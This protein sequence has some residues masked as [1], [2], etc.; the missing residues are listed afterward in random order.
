MYS[1][2]PG[3][4]WRWTRRVAQVV[5]LV[6]IVVA[7]LLGG[8]QRM[9]HTEM[10]KWDNNGWDLPNRVRDRL[11][12]GER[13]KQAYKAL[14]M[15]GGGTAVDY[16]SIPAV[17]PVVGLAAA[18]RGGL[19]GRFIVALLIPLLIGLIAG[20]LFCGWLCPFG[21]LSRAS[22]GIL[23]RLPFRPHRYTIP[24][25]R[26]LRWI[27]LATTV[28]VSAVGVQLMLIYVLPHLLTQQAIYSVW[29]LGGGGAA[30]G[31]LLGLLI[32]GV[33]FGPTLYC[34]T[35]CPTGAV[36]AACGNA[37]A[38]RVSLVDKAECGSHC[39][40]CDR[41]CWLG[42]KP[43]LGDPGPDC[44]LCARCFDACPKANMRVSATKPGRRH[45]PVVAAGLLAMVAFSGRGHAEAARAPVKPILVLNGERVYD[46][47]T[48]ATTV[49]DV[50]GVKLDPDSQQSL[51]GVELS[52]FIAR[53]ERPPAEANGLLKSREVYRG[54]L[55]ITITSANG[56][57]LAVLDFAKPTSPRSTPR[58]TLYRKRLGIRL[59]EGD[60][61]AFGPVPGWID[62]RVSWTI[63]GQ[64]A[65][66]GPLGM[67]LL[68]FAA[69]LGYAGV[70][71]LS[72]ALGRPE[73]SG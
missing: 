18:T 58:G 6:V 61:V 1:V 37:R 66:R 70:L 49:V 55:R 26:T 33:V 44:D 39:T 21:A 8:W 72:L 59:F 57:Q 68:V 40:L 47:V 65:G 30:L 71:S 12:L 56:K 60:T 51:Q 45:L 29:L 24:E 17:D 48:V 38:L 22:Q 32:A 27:I 69:A 23:K 35:L 73:P 43:S 67:L 10:A 7:P 64:G 41:A 19:S 13:P 34:A 63:P 42:L 4:G 36:L 16:A 3:T 5:A 20:R 31:A 28:L 2:S 53:G 11:P 14:E 54:P 50:S 15:T 62:R 52:V 25:R 46:G 9:D